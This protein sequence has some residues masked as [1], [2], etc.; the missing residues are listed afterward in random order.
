M[1]AVAETLRCE[2]QCFVGQQHAFFAVKQ[3][4]WAC[5]VAEIVCE[6]LVPG[7]AAANAVV[8]LPSP[9]PFLLDHRVPRDVLDDEFVVAGLIRRQPVAPRDG[10]FVW[11][12]RLW[13]A[14]TT[15][16]AVILARWADERIDDNGAGN[17]GAVLAAKTHGHCAAK[18]MSHDKRLRSQPCVF[19]DRG[20]FSDAVGVRIFAAL[21]AIAHARKVNR[22]DGSVISKERCDERPPLRM[23]RT[24]MY[25]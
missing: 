24:A 17:I 13:P 3:R 21:R 15:R 4:L 18:T 11:E 10:C 1:V 9:A 5:H 16:P 19:D 22:C 14:G 7:T 12:V 8:I 23:R 20:H 6:R 25:E 2:R